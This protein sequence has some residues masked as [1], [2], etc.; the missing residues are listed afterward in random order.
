MDS[1]W[2]LKPGESYYQRD[3][4]NEAESKIRGLERRYDEAMVRVFVKELLH[5]TR[6]P[7]KRPVY[8]AWLVAHPEQSEK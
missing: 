2:E 1:K 7:S 3:R 5:N 6:S 4:R 8:E